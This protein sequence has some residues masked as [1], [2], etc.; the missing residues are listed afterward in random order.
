MLLLLLCA[1]LVVLF[2]LLYL[3]SPRLP[4]RAVSLNGA[5]VVVTGGSSGIGKAIAIEC[6]KRGAF[7]TLVARN[8]QKLI[9]AKEE[10][11]QHLMNEKQVVQCMSLD[12]SKDFGQVK[13]VM[14]QAQEKLGPVDMLVNCAGFSISAR[15]EDFK[16]EEFRRIMEVNYLGS[17]YPTLAVIPTMKERR[18]GRI[19]FV[20]SQA[21]QI[22]LI[23]YSAYSASKFALRGLSEALQMEVK[24]Y[25]IYITVAYP[26]DTD[27]PGYQEELKS[28][29]E[30]T[31]LISKTSGIFQAAYV[32]QVIVRDTMVG[33]F[34]SSMGSDGYMLT[35]V[36]CGMSPIT[37]VIEALQQVFSMGFFRLISLFYLQSFDGIV[38]R[39]MFRRI[40]EKQSEA[41]LCGS[42]TSGEK[43]DH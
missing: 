21:G 31:V 14:K 20:S 13:S 18:H 12:V 9:D 29:L 24:P 7:V 27:T 39:C 19:V 25:N 3:L 38:R 10:V 30:E 17:V 43:K 2:V 16:P 15:F 26:P 6:V 42:S 22:G 1:A 35:A 41:S 28:A 40:A 32:A 34:S 11:E 36:T 37:S 33:K 5:H 8:E 23:G 4:P